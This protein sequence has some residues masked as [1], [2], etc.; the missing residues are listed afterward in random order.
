MKRSLR[1]L[2]DEERALRQTI[3]GYEQEVIEHHVW[4]MQQGG[5]VT[6]LITTA[7]GDGSP[8]GRAPDHHV[9]RP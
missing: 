7:I 1:T 9:D 5:L 3:A 8:G 2:K 4:L 6:A